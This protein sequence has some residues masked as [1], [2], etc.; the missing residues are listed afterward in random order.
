[1]Y[2]SFSS[3][4]VT[5][6]LFQSL[7]E[8]VDGGIPKL[9]ARRNTLFEASLRAATHRAQQTASVQQQQPQHKPIRHYPQLYIEGEC[10]AG[11]FAEAQELNESGE[12]AEILSGQLD[13]P[14]MRLAT[15]S[16]FVQM[17]AS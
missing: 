1:M 17:L 13:T 4:H 11:S 3:S 10:V 9:R 8:V 6:V 15:M 2:H 14:A 16:S 7:Y 5:I 12:L